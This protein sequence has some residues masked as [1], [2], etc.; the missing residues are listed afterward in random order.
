MKIMSKFWT[1]PFNPVIPTV[2]DDNL[3][4]YEFVKKIFL[5]MQ[6][7]QVE[8]N[9]EFEKVYE[10][11]NEMEGEI[12]QRCKN[13]VDNE[14]KKFGDEVLRLNEKIEILIFELNKKINS[15]KNELE[16]KIMEE[17]GDIL[18]RMT[19]EDL[20]LSQKIVELSMKEA[21]DYNDILI[22]FIELN[23]SVYTEINNLSDNIDSRFENI[24]SLI[25]NKI[26]Q[27]TGDKIIVKN[28]VTGLYETLNK[29][30]NDIYFSFRFG[31]ISAKEYD[32]LKLS[33]KEYD[34]YHISAYD[35]DNYARFIFFEK[36]YLHALW[37]HIDE[38][39]IKFEKLKK[40]VDDSLLMRNPL[41]GEKEVIK[42]VIFDIVNKLHRD[43][44]LSAKE[45]DL[46]ELSAK[47]YD[48]SELSAL[49]Y[50]FNA[51]NLL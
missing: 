16:L 36:L 13:Y 50:D 15:V 34:D 22:K 35:Y 40:Y 44:A 47:I 7:F 17:Y 3:S 1:Q 25:E 49:N 11:F 46:K 8:V 9:K 5:H 2:Y 26:N 31:S 12:F 10:K 48:E 30:L 45:Y 37:S 33:A 24:M 42:E 21:E 28:P 14:I 29:T 32:S 4:Y 6:E 20:K 39:E 38:I 43:G 23:T 18:D 41:S 19:E 51:K 27:T